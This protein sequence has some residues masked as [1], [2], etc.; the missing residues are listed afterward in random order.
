MS[1]KDELSGFEIVDTE[2][3][4]KQIVYRSK[5][6]EAMKG[7]KNPKA[8]IEAANK[9]EE[10]FNFASNN[11]SIGEFSKLMVNAFTAAREG[12]WLI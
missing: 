3:V 2:D 10:F 7:I 12:K 8:F 11:V 1:E 4:L 9:A 5:C 6:Y